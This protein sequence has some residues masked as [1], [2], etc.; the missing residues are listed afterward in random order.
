MDLYFFKEYEIYKAD[1]NKKHKDVFLVFF[2]L[3]I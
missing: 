2:R 1:I 3:R